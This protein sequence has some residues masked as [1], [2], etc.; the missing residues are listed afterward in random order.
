M[1][2]KEEIIAAF[3]RR[4]EDSIE[5]F[6]KDAKSIKIVGIDKPIIKSYDG[7]IQNEVDE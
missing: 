6:C 4:A 7:A 5:H 1:T 2:I 3:I